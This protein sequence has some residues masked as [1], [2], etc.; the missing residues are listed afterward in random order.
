MP[1]K[2]CNKDDTIFDS[3]PEG[4]SKTD[5]GKPRKLTPED[6]LIILEYINNGFVKGAA[7]KAYHPN[8]KSAKSIYNQSSIFFAR[9]EVKRYISD[10]VKKVQAKKEITAEKVMRELSDIG[11]AKIDGKITPHE[12]TEALKVMGEF[13]KMDDPETEIPIG[14]TVVTNI[15]KLV[16]PDNGIGNNKQQ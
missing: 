16:L 8:S 9:P 2:D 14:D 13:L 15:I 12:K 6:L 7:Y 5:G 10:F 1:V 4:N 11:Y 3:P